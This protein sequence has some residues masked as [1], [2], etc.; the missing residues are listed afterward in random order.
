MDKYRFKQLLEST[1]GNVKPLIIENLTTSLGTNYDSLSPE[2]QGLITTL[3]TQIKKS[4]K[5]ITDV[6]I[7][8]EIK[9]EKITSRPDNGGVDQTAL[10]KITELLVDLKSYLK[11]SATTIYNTILQQQKSN[12][13]KFNLDQPLSGYRSYTA[14]IE[15]FRRKVVDDGRTIEDVQRANC[16]PGF[17][18]HHTGK[19]FDIVNQSPQWWNSNLP[20]KTWVENNCGNYGFEITYKTQG[21]LRIAEPWHLYYIG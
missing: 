10:S 2:V 17:S 16:L 12:P 5:Q 20:V 3:N 1:L 19:A 21:S 11:V 4:G 18:Q 7:G 15:E 6:H 8:E 13:T 14:Q 9:Q